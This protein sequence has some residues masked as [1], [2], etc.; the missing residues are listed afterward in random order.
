M[1]IEGLAPKTRFLLR[2]SFA[3]FELDLFF[4]SKNTV[5]L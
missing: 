5:I 3:K 1:M 2:E 4:I